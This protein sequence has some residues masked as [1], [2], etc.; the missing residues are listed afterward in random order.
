MKKIT[1]ACIADLSMVLVDYNANA[2]TTR[3]NIGGQVWH[4]NWDCYQKDFYSYTIH[5]Y[6]TL[7]S[8]YRMPWATLYGPFVSLDLGMKWSI[9]SAFMYTDQ[10]VVNSKYIATYKPDILKKQHHEFIKYDYD[11]LVKYSVVR[12]LSFFAGFKLQGYSSEGGTD[13]LA[14]TYVARTWMTQRVSAPGAGAGLGITIPLHEDL[15]LLA[16][17][18]SVYLKKTSEK[19]WKHLLVPSS[20]AGIYPGLGKSRVHY[21]AFG[22]SSSLSLAYY[23]KP[24]HLT[25]ALGFKH[26]SLYHVMRK[27]DFRSYYT[28]SSLL[29]N[30]QILAQ[31]RMEVWRGINKKFDH[32][33][34]VYA[35]V[36]YSINFSPKGPQD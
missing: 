23:V 12:S 30:M 7:Y 4:A 22:A 19:K 29:E 35:S 32:F 10:F 9:S 18:S 17:G 31:T 25:I 5:R 27:S 24:A 21:D 15:Y 14:L 11:L 33:Y 20:L 26:Q 8:R 3:L 28:S 2:L 16:N 6:S 34:G 13:T 36:V 1:C